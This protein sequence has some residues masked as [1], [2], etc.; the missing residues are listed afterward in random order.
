VKGS[1]GQIGPF[2]LTDLKNY[3]LI[4]C[5]TIPRMI[6]RIR[7]SATPADDPVTVGVSAG[8]ISC[9]LGRLG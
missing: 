3:R 4:R 5:W 7:V 8:P 9:A 2:K 1:D 6:H